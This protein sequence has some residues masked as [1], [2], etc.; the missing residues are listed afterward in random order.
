MKE[1]NSSSNMTLTVSPRTS[2]SLATP[3]VDEP[4]YRKCLVPTIAEVIVL[5]ARPPFPRLSYISRHI[6]SRSRRAFP[7]RVAILSKRTLPYENLYERVPP[8]GA[9]TCI[10]LW[11]ISCRC[12]FMLTLIRGP[13]LLSVLAGQCFDFLPSLVMAI[14]CEHIMLL[15][16]GS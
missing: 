10:G 16:G 5:T 4:D 14:F 3:C 8:P 9:G 1:S 6:N 2:A 15:S 13:R 12:P 7:S 11:E